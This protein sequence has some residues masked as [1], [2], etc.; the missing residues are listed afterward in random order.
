M[1]CTTQLSTGT[2]LLTIDAHYRSVSVLEFSHD[3]AALISG[4]EDAGVSVW[5]VGR[6]V[7]ATNGGR[8]RRS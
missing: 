1:L 3:D 8:L 4:A 2:L 7:E 5:N 6:C